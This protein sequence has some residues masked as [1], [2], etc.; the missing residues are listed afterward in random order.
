MTA[1]SA[2]LGIMHPGATA[3]DAARVPSAACVF[4]AP[5]SSRQ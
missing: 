2:K 5:L 1:M 3:A 4:L